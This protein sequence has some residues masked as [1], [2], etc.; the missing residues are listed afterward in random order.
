MLDV[1]PPHASVHTWK[2]FLLHM[3]TIVLG[4]LIAIGLEQSVEWMHHREQRHQLLEQLD[5][6]HQQTLKDAKD[7]QLAVAITLNWNAKRMMAMQ[8][9]AWQNQ[10]YDKPALLHVSLYNAPDNPVWRAANASG[11][12]S[13]LAQRTIILN[14]EPERL[15]NEQ[16]E[17]LLD[18]LRV[19]GEM[20]KACG[21]L[22]VQ[23]SATEPADSIHWDR[24]DVQDCI[25][26]MF[27][28]YE[29]LRNFYVRDAYVI[30]AEEAI[31][32]GETNI[33]RVND[34]EIQ[35][36][37]AASDQLVPIPQPL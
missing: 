32:A 8:A 15:L 34:R 31:E 9:V 12:T 20:A 30:G 13:L 19:R 22:P 24:N 27:A 35:E 5:A 3:T 4:L 26:G 23:S 25:G 37:L 28:Y 7:T 36:A 17:L 29:A 11:L 16:K 1:H 2:D 6:E 33:D 18:L 21:R 10:R 14:A